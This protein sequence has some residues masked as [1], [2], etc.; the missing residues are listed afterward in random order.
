[1]DKLKA[2][3]ERGMTI[4]SKVVMLERE[5]Q[6]LTLVDTGGHWKYTKNTLSGMSQCDIGV[7]V[8]SANK[9]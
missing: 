8:I 6:I 9:H 1:M 3:K 2:E 7:V 5:K 4:V